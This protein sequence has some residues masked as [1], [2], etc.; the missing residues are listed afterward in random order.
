MKQKKLRS[1]DSFWTILSYP[2]FDNDVQLSSWHSRATPLCT[3]WASGLSDG[4]SMAI[5]KLVECPVVLRVPLRSLV[6]YTGDLYVGLSGI[7]LLLAGFNHICTQ[8]SRVNQYYYNYV[9][10]LV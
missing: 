5:T 8:Q 10:L 7:S 1:R 4:I 3:Q 2:L 6:L 9:L